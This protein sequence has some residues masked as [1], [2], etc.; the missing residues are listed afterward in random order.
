MDG[1]LKAILSD[2]EQMKGFE[3]EMCPLCLEV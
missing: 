1:F 2:D 3:F